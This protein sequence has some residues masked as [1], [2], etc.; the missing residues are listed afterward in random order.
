MDQKFLPLGNGGGLTIIQNKKIGQVVISK[1][2]R[3]KGK[4]FLII[5]IVNENYVMAVDGDLRKV[6]NPKMKN[7][8]HLQFTNIIAEDVVELLSKGILPENHIIRK[9]LKNLINAREN[10]GKEV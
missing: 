4:P 3:D 7:V 8:K 2:G 5:E 9:S 1:A 6:E 10:Y